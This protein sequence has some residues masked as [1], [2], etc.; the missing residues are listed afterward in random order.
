MGRILFFVLLAVAIWIAWSINRRNARLND[1]ERRE[2]E[3]LRSEQLKA[4]AQSRAHDRAAMVRCDG[5]GVFFPKAEA[6]LREN[7]VYCSESCR[8]KDRDNV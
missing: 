7:R 4:Q 6:R 5:C 1:A 2:L 8:D 3:R